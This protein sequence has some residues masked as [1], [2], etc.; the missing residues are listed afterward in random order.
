M[1][2]MTNGELFEDVHVNQLIDNIQ[3]NHDNKLDKGSNTL[4]SSLKLFGKDGISNVTVKDDHAD[5]TGNSL[6]KDSTS[7]LFDRG[8]GYS[9]TPDKIVFQ[10][11]TTDS[12]GN[13]GA[14]STEYK[15]T[16]KNIELGAEK[17][18]INPT[19]AF[20]V[21]GAMTVSATDK[22]AKFNTK[23]FESKVQNTFTIKDTDSYKLFETK[24]GQTTVNTRLDVIERERGNT[25]SLRID[26]FE[27]KVNSS[28]GVTNWQKM[29]AGGNPFAFGV[30]NNS[31][32]N[33]S[34]KTSLLNTLPNGDIYLY[35]VG[36]YN[37]LSTVGSRS[38]QT[39]ISN[40]ENKNIIET[41][42]V[43]GVTVPV[44]DKT[45]ELSS[46]QGPKG[47]KGDPGETGPQGPQ[48]EQG[49]QGPQGEQGP[50]GPQGEQGP[51]GPN[52]NVSVK[53]V[54]EF[55]NQQD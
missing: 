5:L 44:I 26:A 9:F 11:Y 31:N 37:G 40:L 14:V 22:A 15:Q 45:V 34:E 50:Q 46:S 49:P 2:H 48:G 10:N 54:I 8:I 12:D 30:E 6:H 18:I 16:T 23:T 35:G 33:D 7:G 27:T 19:S 21:N 32:I 51:E 47:D 43:D 4:D 25:L 36:G 24:S 13:I 53:E 3:D 55:L 20:T 1:E 17:V 42:K 52:P 41:I 28:G 29:T 38:L 39:V